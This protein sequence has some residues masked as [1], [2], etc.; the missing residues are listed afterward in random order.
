MAELM[1]PGENINLEYKYMTY[2]NADNKGPL[3]K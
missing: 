2:A 3:S 1:K